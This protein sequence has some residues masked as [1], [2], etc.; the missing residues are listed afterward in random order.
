MSSQTTDAETK[1][2]GLYI[3]GE[4]RQPEG[5]AETTVTS[6]ATGEVVATIPQATEDDVDEA[7]AVAEQAQTEW[8]QTP[9]QERAAVIESAVERLQERQDEV[10]D[11]L[12]REAGS[13]VPKGA[14]EVQLATG[15]MN[16]ATSFPFRDGGDH[17]KSIIP[18]KENVV[19][20]E[21]VGVVGVISPWNFPFHLSMRAVAPALALGNAV[22]LKP[23]GDTPITG[24]LLL[25]DIFEE[26]GLP[27][28]LLNVVPGPGS[29]VGDAVASDERAEVVAFTGST[30]VGRQVAQRA[31]E[32]FAEPALELGGNNVHIVTDD[33]DLEQAV[34]AGVFGTFMHQG[35]VCISIN[36]HL[37]HED[38]YDEY[39]ERLTE[40]AAQLPA[41][42]EL[43]EVV[44][45]PIINETQR[46]TVLEFI[47]ETVEAGATLETGG[48]ADGLVIEPTVLS[49]VT[50]DMAAACN[51]HFGPVAPVIPFSDDDEAVEMAN[52]TEYGLSGAVHAG[53]LERARDIADRVE[54]GMIHINDQPINDEPHVPFGG[55]GASGMGRYNAEAILRK[56]TRTKWV[57]IQREQR[58]YPF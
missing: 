11:L 16:V 21:P 28:G 29:T 24:G 36:R 25:A 23:A 5:A 53:D 56:F 7:Y 51:E 17:E 39:V 30:E 9:P 19:E 12:G 45:G 2:N 57:S 42:T 54:T 46:D 33:A 35:Q 32:N 18:G 20:R 31:A 22:V 55:V 4:W 38:V 14:K 1:W 43:D 6:P 48:E 15:M 49:D 27:D 3:D 37:V 58:E 10:V 50:N 13:I 41:G 40:R 8:A 34:D 26:A 47:E 44:V 52:A